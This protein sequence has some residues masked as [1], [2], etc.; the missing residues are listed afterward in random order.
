MTRKLMAPTK[1]APMRAFRGLMHDVIN[2]FV[3]PDTVVDFDRLAA[4]HPAIDREHLRGLVDAAERVL[5]DVVG[6]HTPPIP[7][8]DHHRSPAQTGGH[9]HAH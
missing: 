5:L 2:V 8:G 1:A 6:A 7:G 3:T 4:Y 9:R